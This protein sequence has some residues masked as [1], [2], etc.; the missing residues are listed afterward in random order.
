M[1]A[2]PK[3]KA[4]RRRLMRWGMLISAMAAMAVGGSSWMEKKNAVEVGVNWAPDEKFKLVVYRVAP[5]MGLGGTAGA[6]SA[7]FVVL[8]TKEGKELKRVRF[9]S[10]QDFQDVRWQS[11]AVVVNESMRWPL[12]KAGDKSNDLEG[13]GQKGVP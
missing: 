1:P 4:G 5:G 12:P 8:Q 2:R 10:L 3:K 9:D 7:A 11:D 13:A 6:D